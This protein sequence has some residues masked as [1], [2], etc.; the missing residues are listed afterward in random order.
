LDNKGSLKLW[1]DDAT[2]LKLLLRNGK[3]DLA[4]GKIVLL[5]GLRWLKGG[6]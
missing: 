3:S 2:K 4:P 1:V 5:E 6:M